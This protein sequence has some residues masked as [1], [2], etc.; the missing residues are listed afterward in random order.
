M[1]MTPMLFSVSY[2]GY[3]GQHRLDLP[4]FFAKAAALGYPA[5][6]I[7]AKRPH[8][9]V[10]D[11][12]DEGAE[13]LRAAARAAG[14]EIGTVAAYNNFTMGRSSPEVPAVEIQ[15]A[16]L[17][18][19]ARLARCVGARI[20]RVFSGYFTGPDDFQANWDTC[21][22]ALREGAALCAAHGVRLGLQNHH[23]VGL[24][25][26]ML[27]DLVGEVGH[28]NLKTMFD[29]WSAQLV[30]DRLGDV[31]RRMAPTMVQTTLADYVRWERF[32]YRPAAI[33][34][35]RVDPPQLRAVPLGQGFMDLD[36]FLAGLREGG[37]AGYVAYEM[38]SPLRG[39]GTE[40]NLDAAARESLR[41]IRARI[42][43]A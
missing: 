3:W 10:L 2:A 41:W 37:F 27:V 38:C 11:Y 18:R 32:A 39:G 20:V 19:V 5:V 29:P 4:A 26:D 12:D 30:G 8:L 21:V 28:E 13:Q 25:A 1:P 43:G 31:A 34:Y 24:T 14:V 40:A 9:S 7:A 23:D 15:L 17:D 6:E 35:E 22:R 33:N 36:A 16:Y 42:G